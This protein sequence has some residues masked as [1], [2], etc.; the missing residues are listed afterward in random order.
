MNASTNASSGLGNRFTGQACNDVAERG[1]IDSKAACIRSLPPLEASSG[2]WEPS[3]SRLHV[4]TTLLASLTGAAANAASESITSSTWVGSAVALR[5]AV[6]GALAAACRD[7][8]SLCAR[9]YSDVMERVVEGVHSVEADHMRAAHESALVTALC[10]L[11]VFETGLSSRSEHHESATDASRAAEAIA[12]LVRHAEQEYALFCAANALAQGQDRGP[13]H[14][15]THSQP[16]TTSAPESGARELGKAQAHVQ[17]LEQAQEQGREQIKEQAHPETEE[18]IQERLMDQIQKQTMTIVDKRFKAAESAR[19]EAEEQA[20]SHAAAA[21][22]AQSQTEDMRAR[23]EAAEHKLLILRNETEQLREQLAA[24]RSRDIEQIKIGLEADA[25]S[26]TRKQETLDLIHQTLR[27]IDVQQREG[28]VEARK[29]HVAASERIDEAATTAAAAAAAAA[30][31]STDL[32][33]IT[34]TRAPWVDNRD[35][36]RCWQCSKNFGLLVRR[37]HCRSCGAVFCGKCS[38]HR[39]PIASQGYEEAVR[40]CDKCYHGLQQQQ[41]NG[42]DGGAKN[43]SECEGTPWQ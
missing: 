41:R 25:Q 23:A 29:Q 16:R 8:V 35:A 30:E 4:S 24:R 33:G 9:V 34:Q 14:S 27:Q 28:A 39:S 18:Q 31:T 15:Q 22:V 3:N 38:S 21:R 5:D 1:R 2:M 6:D 20:K 11:V 7:H 12:Q 37:H 36:T 19:I 32:S 26:M 40:V 17:V 42:D 13:S 43:D 10:R